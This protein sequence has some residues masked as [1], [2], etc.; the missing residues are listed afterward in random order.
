MENKELPYDSFEVIYHNQIN[1]CHYYCLVCEQDSFVIGMLNIRFEE[2]LHHSKRI[3]E[4]LEFAVA[5]A[6]RSKGIGKEMFAQ[7]C[8]IA[9]D[10]SCSQIEVAWKQLL[11]SGTN[12]CAT[13]EYGRKL[14]RDIM[15][16][17]DGDQDRYAKLSGHGFQMLANAMEA[18]LPYQI[19]CPALLICG[20]YDKAGS[21]KRY[22]KA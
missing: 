20:D 10:N 22:N 17:Y 9:T 6:Y 21:T 2:Q 14:M 7:S 5:S 12:G 1:D 16:V 4:I 15:M 19:N 13:S 3:A 8:Q 11:H 18:D